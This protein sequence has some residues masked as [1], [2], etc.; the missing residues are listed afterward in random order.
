MPITRHYCTEQLVKFLQEQPVGELVTY[1]QLGEVIHQGCTSHPDHR[2]GYGYLCS[3]R[4]ILLNEHQIVFGTVQKEGI[5]R[6]DS[7]GISKQVS[8]HRKHIH[9]TAKVSLKT[10]VCANENEMTPEERASHRANQAVLAMTE[11]S[12]RTAAVKQIEQKTRSVALDLQKTIEHFKNA[13][14][15]KDHN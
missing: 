12:T 10:S 7:P 9:K 6:L 5:K 15:G 3:A 4:K 11:H 2:R 14:D 8:K 13:T 1:D